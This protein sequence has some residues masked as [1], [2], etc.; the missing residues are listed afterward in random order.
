MNCGCASQRPLY[1]SSDEVKKR[2][3]ADRRL[4]EAA[5]VFGY[6]HVVLFLFFIFY[7]LISVDDTNEGRGLRGK[8]EGFSVSGIQST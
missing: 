3:C 2:R 1:I 8:F 4:E 5:F 7:E 6:W